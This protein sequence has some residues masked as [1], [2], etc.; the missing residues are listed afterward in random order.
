M[1]ICV[2][3]GAK[4]RLPGMR[5]PV[6]TAKAKYQLLYVS[7]GRNSEQV[8]LHVSQI[9]NDG[10]MIYLRAHGSQCTYMRAFNLGRLWLTAKASNATVM[11]LMQQE[12]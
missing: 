11:Y 12:L 3:M 7:L 9:R 1:M 8:L 4:A 6:M 2:R 5:L 10:M